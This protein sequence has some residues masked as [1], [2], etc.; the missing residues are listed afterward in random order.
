[1][2]TFIAAK[3]GFLPFIL[4]WALFLGSPRAAIFGALALSLIANFWAW[5]RAETKQLE[6]AGAVIFVALAALLAIDAP[7]ALANGLPLSFLGLGLAGALTVFWR[8]PW[9]ADYSRAAFPQM[10]ENPIFQ[11]INGALSTLWSVIF[12]ALAALHWLHVSAFVSAGLTAA[13]A[14][15]SIFGPKFLIRRALSKIIAAQE[16]CSWA[17]PTFDATRP[18]D[19]YDVAVVGAGVGGLTAA[20]LLADQGLRVGVFEHHVLPGG[21]CHSWLRKQMHQGAPLLFRFDAGPHD[22]S[23]AH[24]GGSLDVLLKRLNVAD[25]IEWLRLDHRYIEDGQTL[26]PP[27][28]WR[29]FVDLLAKA[30]PQDGEG[31]HAFFAAMKAIYDGM[32]SDVGA[33]GGVPG[34]PRSVE[35]MLDVAKRHP[36][37]AQWG[38]RPFKQLLRLHVKTEPAR[39]A[40]MRLTGYIGDDPDV[41]TCAAM[42]PIFGYYFN[43][44]FYPK[45][46]TSRFAEVLAGAVEARGGGFST[47]P[48]SPKSSSKT[49]APAGFASS[50]GAF[51]PLRPVWGFPPASPASARRSRSA[52]VP[53]WLAS[54]PSDNP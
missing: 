52:V 20:A 54:A 32:F 44:G 43:G 45:G 47:S 23:G 6:L 15:A 35:A 48:A 11:E 28:D 13:G 24:P 22:F 40:L 10:A 49:G 9:T 1:M 5:R 31:V 27:R 17:P 29:E 51:A 53:G 41:L 19:V 33:N 3:I 46:G 21:F 30:H 37:L 25:E 14:L 18:D 34:D 26:D 8:K 16:D 4:F 38:E 42:A 7:F 12:I 36:L 39:A 2:R 50:T